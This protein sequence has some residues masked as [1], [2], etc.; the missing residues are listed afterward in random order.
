MMNKQEKKLNIVGALSDFVIFM[1]FV[2]GAGFAGYFIGINQQVAPIKIIP[3]GTAAS[4]ELF[5]TDLL[6]LRS[7]A[8]ARPVPL[9]S[10]S[11]ATS[12][13]SA[14]RA[15]SENKSESSEKQKSG[16]QCVFRRVRSGLQ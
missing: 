16:I 3:P 13:E 12:T 14:A 1:L 11:A 7:N 6:G 10:N 9:G 15:E 4:A 5:M 8:P 2:S